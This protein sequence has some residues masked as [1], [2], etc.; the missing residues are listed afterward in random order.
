[1]TFCSIFAALLA[2]S[3]GSQFGI[4]SI[5]ID[6][7]RA[8]S[9][10][11]AAPVAWGLVIKPPADPL[12]HR[13]ILLAVN[14][15]SDE[16]LHVGML[17]R[18]LD[19]PT[20]WTE[21]PDAFAAALLPGTVYLEVARWSGGP[22]MTNV[23]YAWTKD[24]TAAS[25]IRHAERH[26]VPSWEDDRVVGYS[27]GF[28]HWGVG[29]QITICGRKPFARQDLDRAFVI[30]KSIRFP[31]VPVLDRRQAIEVALPFVSGDVHDALIDSIE[32]GCCDPYTVDAQATATGFDVTVD[33]LDSLRSRRVVKSE[34]LHVRR[35]GAVF[36]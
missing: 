16:T 15:R 20:E 25:R 36:R 35:D 30:L 4:Q 21:G 19:F 26:R 7:T 14:N 12:S 17:R 31:D 1:M 13:N 34:V 9:V 22:S 2:V 5:P 33:I 24:Q 8:L 27:V 18:S 28:A 23:P 6:D 10:E 3:P 11:V 32:C 29:W